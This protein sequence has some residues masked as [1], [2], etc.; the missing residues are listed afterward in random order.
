MTLLRLARSAAAFAE[1]IV[2][3]MPMTDEHTAPFVG[4]E[5]CATGF[6]VTALDSIVLKHVKAYG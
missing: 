3:S 6:R 4:N 5:Y 2:Y 1:P